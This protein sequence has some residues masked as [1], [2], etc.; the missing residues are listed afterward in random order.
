MKSGQ[1]RHRVTFRRKSAEADVYGV[2]GNFEDM[3]TAWGNVRIATGK[4]RVQNGS[5]EGIIHATIRIRDSATARTLLSSDQAVA[6]GQKWNLEQPTPVDDDGA[7][8]D[9]KCTSGGPQ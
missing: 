2:I 3:F 5:V 4:E 6:R 8:W 1:L 9:L 7:F